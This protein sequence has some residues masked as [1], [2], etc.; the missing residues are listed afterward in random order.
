LETTLL[1]QRNAA[2]LARASATAL[3]IK[4][5]ELIS[6]TRAATLVPQP[7]RAAHYL[8]QPKTQAVS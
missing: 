1:S 5:Y 7:R 6:A 2:S 3:C 8:A 4:R